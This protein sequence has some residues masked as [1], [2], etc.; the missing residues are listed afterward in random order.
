MQTRVSTKGED[1]YINGE[2]TYSELKDCDTQYHGLLMNARFIQGLF[3]EKLEPSRFNRF[4][5]VFDPD[6]NSD[7]LIESLPLWYCNGLRAITIGLQGGVVRVTPLI[8]VR[9]R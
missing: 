7:E 5:R 4:G 2:K 8:T 9:G 1:F 6:Q 3:D